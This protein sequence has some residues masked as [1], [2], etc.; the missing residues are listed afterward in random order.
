MI[1]L[2]IAAGF[3]TLA[4]L[5]LLLMPLLR[6]RSVAAPERAD[7]DL[8]VYREQLAEI[9]RDLERDLMTAEQAD[10]ARIEIK[11]RM[12]A[13]ADT[14]DHAT[15][16]TASPRLAWGSAVTMVIAVPLVAFA[17][18]WSLGAPQ[19]P[20]LPWASR[21]E[22]AAHAETKAREGAR[23]PQIAEAV[24]R[25]EERLSAKPED[26]DGWALLGRSS[27][28][29]ERYD[30]AA[31][32]FQK[33]MA[34]SDE[35]DATI[36]AHYG[37]ALVAAADGQITDDAREAFQTAVNRNPRAVKARYYLALDAAQQ[38]DLRTA[39][40]GWTDVIAMSPSDAPWLPVVRQQ[41]QRAAEEIGVDP[42][43]LTPSLETLALAKKDLAGPAKPDVDQAA[44]I[45][46]MVDRLAARLKDEPDDRDGWLRLARAYEVLGE[47]EKARKARARAEAIPAQ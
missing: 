47:T 12:L 14:R 11:R 43:T 40:Q 25:L 3:L 10:A 38:G 1:G 42:S 37:E 45:R 26:R 9:D 22:P 16:R 7:Y 23:P 21:P 29:M 28:S 46:A 39:V 20:D 17:L 4:V 5:A 24:A 33:A 35:N 13:A 15:P 32:A 44:M 31:N 36:A 18:Y 27:L 34:L 8:S 41:V 2:W 19:T 30:D 6:K